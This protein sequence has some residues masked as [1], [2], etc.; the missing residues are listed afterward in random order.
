MAQLL[1]TGMEPSWL[2]TKRT[3]K[4]GKPT[5]LVYF[6]FLRNYTCSEKM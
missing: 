2:S 1:E 5:P 4:V 6:N 3:L